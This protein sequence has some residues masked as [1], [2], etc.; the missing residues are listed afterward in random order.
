MAK[1]QK[2]TLY[3]MTHRPHD[4]NTNKQISAC[5]FVSNGKPGDQKPKPIYLLK[6]QNLDTP[7][8]PALVLCPAKHCKNKRQ[9]VKEIAFKVA[10]KKKDNENEKKRRAAAMHDAREPLNREET[11]IQESSVYLPSQ[12]PHMRCQKFPHMRC[13]ITYWRR[14]EQYNFYCVIQ[15]STNVISQ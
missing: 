9:M 2:A 15:D 4:E 11:D 8:T 7:C 10:K 6:I 13:I 3:F 1:Q 12:K 5:H 14:W